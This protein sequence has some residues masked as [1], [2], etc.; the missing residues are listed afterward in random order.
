[1]KSGKYLFWCV[2]KLVINHHISET[3]LLTSKIT[4]IRSFEKHKEKTWK[5]KLPENLNIFRSYIQSF[6]MKNLHVSMIAK[7]KSLALE[8]Y[9]F[10]AKQGCLYFF[11]VCCIKI[12]IFYVQYAVEV[13]RSKK[14]VGQWM[15]N[16]FILDVMPKIK[17]KKIEANNSHFH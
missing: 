15:K 9:S 17:T 11:I 16:W 1:M 4:F 8:D 14:E 10:F 5:C 12:K 3:S 7:F 13:N 2:Y 6:Y